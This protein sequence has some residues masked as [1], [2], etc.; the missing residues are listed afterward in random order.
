[1]ENVKKILED[2]F[3]E[4]NPENT[5]YIPHHSN[6]SWENCYKFFYDNHEEIVE[7]D[8]KPE[9]LDIAA[10]HLAF[11]LASWGMYRGDTFLR[12]YDHTAYKKL[13]LNLL[14]K[15]YYFFK[16]GFVSWEDLEKAQITITKH[17]KELKIRGEKYKNEPTQTLITKILMGIFGC[18]PA[19]DR[20]VITALQKYN[21]EVEKENRI[22]QTFNNKSYIKLKDWWERQNYSEQHYL[23]DSKIKY[24]PMKLVDVYFW[25]IGLE[26]DKKNKNKR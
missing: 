23:K 20:F 21:S 4:L 15:Y 25:S 8:K 16:C 2:Y 1:M 18:V 3:K 6:L 5:A 11:Y 12:Q 9:L 10:L 24:P 14:E 19:Y 22:S 7:N 26:L 17:F 13:I